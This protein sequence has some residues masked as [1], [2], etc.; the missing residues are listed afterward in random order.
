LLAQDGGF[1]ILDDSVKV[2]TIHSAKG[3][4][5]PVVLL[6]GL[7]DGVLPMEV[8]GIDGEVAQLELERQRT[9]MY[10]GMTRAAEALYLVTSRQAPSPFLK[11][12]GDLVCRE[13]FAGSKA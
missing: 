2:L 9:L 7:H 11:E 12:I 6:V 8:R 3:L 13:P 10:V 4:E 5:F 1:D